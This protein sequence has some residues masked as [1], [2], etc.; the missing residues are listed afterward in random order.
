[1]RIIAGNLKGRP[2][3]TPSGRKTRPTSDKARGAIFDVL[4]HASW[5]PTL[6]AARILDLFAGSGALGLEALSRGGQ[7]CLFVET[8]AQA[9]QAIAANI[10]KL[11][12]NH[13]AATDRRSA[14]RLGT[15][16]KHHAH[17][18]VVFIDPPYHKNLIGPALQSIKDGGWISPGAAIIIETAQDE[19]PDLKDWIVNDHRVYGAAQFHCL[20]APTVSL[21]S[22]PDQ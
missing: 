5:A 19:T 14:V 11:G 9:R 17:F 4:T 2:L 12:L 6:S 16:P 20:T 10:G 18:D 13:S 3:Q 7:Y 22:S 21:S 8:E 1:M 15:R